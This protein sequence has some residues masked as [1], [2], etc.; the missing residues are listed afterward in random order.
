MSAEPSAPAS[1]SSEDERRAAL[2]EA[3]ER[4]EDD[5]RSLIVEHYFEKTS[6][7]QLATR[8]G[9][10]NEAIWKRI[11]RA[12]QSLKETL[13]TLGMATLVPDPDFV[14][15]ACVP[16]SLAT[17]LV[18]GV[19]AK[20]TVTAAAATPAVLASAAMHLWPGGLLMTVKQSMW[21]MV[22]G[23]AV[24]LCVL[25][26]VGGFII[27]SFQND[28]ASQ[29]RLQGIGS[30]PGGAVGTRHTK[31]ASAHQAEP[32]GDKRN[33]SS[34]VNSLGARLERYRL[35]LD[36]QFPDRAVYIAK[37]GDSSEGKELREYLERLARWRKK[38]LEGLRELV[39]SD[40]GPLLDFLRSTSAG[41]YLE[42]LL[43]GILIP[44]HPSLVN[45]MEASELPKPLI[46]GL[47]AI[48]RTG[49][50]EQ[51]VAILSFA[52]TL[53][54][55]SSELIE[56]IWSSIADPDTTVQEAALLSIHRG[57][58][59]DSRPLT[60]SQAA[61]LFQ[62]MQYVE[63]AP[64][65]ADACLRA[66]LARHIAIK[67]RAPGCAD[68]FFRIAESTNHPNTLHALGVLALDLRYQ[69]SDTAFEQ[70]LLRGIG[71]A[72]ERDNSPSE[73][74]A[75]LFILISGFAPAKTLPIL[76]RALAVAPTTE[77]AD[78][79]RA[80]GTAIRSGTTDLEELGKLVP[81]DLKQKWSLVQ[82]YHNK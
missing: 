4:I 55:A 82:F 13:S 17:N 68:W 33:T 75:C 12:R 31:E 72:I 39:L 43:E 29:G 57:E 78:S 6:L 69:K 61:P 1:D 32:P 50:R 79:L 45:R 60:A 44:G 11:T 34:D 63:T 41:G 76:D 81:A 35:Q 2:L 67:A 20:V 9:L 54:H 10:S 5:E 47:L 18:P 51:K 49:S 26:L 22:A 71:E 62:F 56:T 27:R 14:L 65:N 46:D 74:G 36:L 80:M 28:P 19:M 16:V 73:F 37:R 3:L 23:S 66:D 8:K 70:R 7:T 59:M 64:Y 52:G 42:G 48:L 15:E 30:T 24:V 58:L 38:E 53:D 21:S 77:W 25:V 40:P